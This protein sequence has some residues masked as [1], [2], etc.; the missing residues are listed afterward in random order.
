MVSQVQ[1]ILEKPFLNWILKF[2]ATTNNAIQIE[3][4][5]NNLDVKD[6]MN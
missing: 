6:R 5:F 1:N 4:I 3:I 2:N